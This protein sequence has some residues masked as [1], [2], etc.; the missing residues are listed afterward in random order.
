MQGGNTSYCAS[1]MLWNQRNTK[2]PSQF[3]IL[4]A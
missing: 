4:Y 3:P 2:S 1:M